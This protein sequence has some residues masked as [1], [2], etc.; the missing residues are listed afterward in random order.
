MRRCRYDARC[1]AAWLRYAE[2][3]AGWAYRA[4]V[5]AARGVARPDRRAQHQQ[6]LRVGIIGDRAGGREGRERRDRGGARGRGRVDEQRAL[7]RRS[8]RILHQRRIAAARALRAAGAGGRPAGE[9]RRH[10]A[11]RTRRGCARLATESC[12]CGNRSRPASLARRDRRAR[13]RGVYP[14]ANERGIARRR[15]GGLW[16]VAGAI[17][18]RTRRRDL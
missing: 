4:G 12:C 10:R 13:R 8:R 5:E 14:A 7:P 2:R 9:Q 16:R 17:C 15:T 3:R 1:A 6:L 18:G 11:R